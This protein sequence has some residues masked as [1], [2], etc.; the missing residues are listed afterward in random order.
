M[1]TFLIEEGCNSGVMKT[2][3]TET[4]E[5]W[6]LKC[7]SDVIVHN[8]SLYILNTS[9]PVLQMANLRYILK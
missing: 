7:F 3:N 8:C 5:N 4:V 2:G 9:C 1:L 6:L